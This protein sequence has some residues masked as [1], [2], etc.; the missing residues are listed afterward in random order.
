MLQIFHLFFGILKINIFCFHFS[1][2]SIGMGISGI[3][4]VQFG[5][6]ISGFGIVRVEDKRIHLLLDFDPRF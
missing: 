2:N 3:V 1:M 6:G 4:T 5:P